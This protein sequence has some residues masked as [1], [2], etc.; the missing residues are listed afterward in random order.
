LK[1]PQISKQNTET[2]CCLFNFHFQQSNTKACKVFDESPTPKL[3]GFS[4][5]LQLR[6]FQVTLM[7]EEG[8]K[9]I[10]Y[11]RKRYRSVEGRE[12][13]M[14]DT[15][16]NNANL[17]EDKEDGLIRGLMKALQDI[18]KGQRETREFM[19]KITSYALGS[20]ILDI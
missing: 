11:R 15:P 6:I 1:D 17:P 18:A 16:G 10:T 8:L 9:N 12:E 7:T 4:Q 2:H 5:L 14:G 3:E 19:G 13:E 20:V